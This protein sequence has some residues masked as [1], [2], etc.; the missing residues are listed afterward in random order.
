MNDGTSGLRPQK[1]PAELRQM[2]GQ[3]LRI[4]AQDF[5]SISRLCR[6]LG[7]NR[8][9]FNR[10]LSGESFPRPDVLHRICTFFRV[11]ARILLEPLADLSGDKGV[12]NHPLIAEYVGSGM[13]DIPQDVFPDGFYRFSRRSFIEQDLIIIGLVYVFRKDDHT[14]IRGYEAKEAMQEQGLPTDSATREFRGVIL[15]Q[16]DGVAAL[17]SHART[18][19]TSFN[20]L[21]R[22]ASFQNHYWIGYATR[23]VRETVTGCRAARLVYEH[24]GNET[25]PVLEAARTV[26]FCSPDN[27]MPYHRKLLQLERP[28]S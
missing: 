19:A 7:I 13:T 2:L 5:P 22:V 21:S 8:T 23:T 1:S 15:P 20:Y 9:Q 25:G 6:E 26:G 14:F 16:E 11:D 3:N 18:M 24:L 4:L 28:F 12:L 10:Y 17:V 27:L